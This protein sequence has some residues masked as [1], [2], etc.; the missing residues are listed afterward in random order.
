MDAAAKDSRFPQFKSGGSARTVGGVAEFLVEM[1][2]SRTIPP[3][4]VPRSESVSRVAEQMTREGRQVRLLSS[5]VVPVEETCFYVFEAQ[6]AEVVREAA[7]RAG[8]RFERVVEATQSIPP[9]TG[10]QQT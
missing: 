7:T 1:Y 8:L 9:T 2:V 10:E 6:T 4:G 5:I 3:S